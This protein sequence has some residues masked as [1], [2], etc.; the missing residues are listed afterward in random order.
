MRQALVL[1][2][3][4]AIGVST[5]T[6]Q[7]SDSEVKRDFEK[8]FKALMKDLREADSASIRS[9]A[10]KVAAF[11]N[12]FTEHRDFLNKSV[13]PDGFDETISKLE[14]QLKESQLIADSQG[15]IR[16][17]ESQVAE[18]TGRIDAMSSENAMLLK[19]LDSLKGEV[20]ELNAKVRR[21]QDNITKRDVAVFALVDSLFVQYDTQRLSTG[22]MRKLSSLEKNNV[23]GNIKR[24]VNDNIALLSSSGIEALDFP[25]M[26]DEQR[27]FEKNWKGVGKKLADAYVGA[28]DR[29]REITAVDTLISKWHS[30]VDEA[31]WKALNKVFTDEQVNVA[32][33]A[34]GE[35]L[36]NN[37]LKFIDDEMSN[38]GNMDDAA[39]EA[40]FEKFAYNIWGAKLKPV[41]IPIMKRYEIFTDSQE[42]EIDTKVKLW[43]SQV[44]PGNTLLY[45]LVGALVIAVLVGLYLGMKKRPTTT[46]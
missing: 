32:S 19:Q 16:D 25:R 23:V 36:Y 15:R 2:I 38:A 11:K 28:K 44:A 22:D 26:L 46:A 33:V 21:L 34:S 27:K 9:Y 3:A 1:C 14:D 10:E 43:Q 37:I 12:E 5:L 30:Q 29:A 39:R 35:E 45:I 20:A 40:T 4:L 17:L 6:A 31:F 13:Y 18:L 7:R 41:W 8:G 42:S 24:S